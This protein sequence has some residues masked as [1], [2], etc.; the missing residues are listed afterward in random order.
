[1]TSSVPIRNQE[2]ISQDR[3][4]SFRNTPLRPDLVQPLTSQQREMSSLFTRNQ[5]LSQQQ[6]QQQHIALSAKTVP[7]RPDIL[8]Q[9]FSSQ[10]RPSENANGIN[11]GQTG[12]LGVHQLERLVTET[13][14]NRLNL[15]VKFNG[16]DKVNHQRYFINGLR[17][18][19]IQLRHSTPEANIRLHKFGDQTQIHIFRKN[20]NANYVKSADINTNF[21]KNN[22]IEIKPSLSEHYIPVAE[23]NSNSAQSTHTATGT[24]DLMRSDVSALHA[25]SLTTDNAAVDTIAFETIPDVSTGMASVI[26]AL[27]SSQPTAVVKSSIT[28]K[29]HIA[30]N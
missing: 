9:T 20:N 22:G 7:S 18:R 5:P 8:L 29:L 2:Q 10:R 4:S 15:N 27:P 6:Q 17:L 26:S 25:Q 19:N 14:D 23:S 16:D 24:R 1:M 21:A 30:Y 12:T 28:R 11:L 13:Q 3:A